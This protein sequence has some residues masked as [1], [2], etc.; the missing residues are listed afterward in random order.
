MLN[1][2]TVIVTEK[3]ADQVDELRQAVAQAVL[4]ALSHLAAKTNV[5]HSATAGA[6]HEHEQKEARRNGSK[7]KARRYPKLSCKVELSYVESFNFKVY[8]KTAGVLANAERESPFRSATI[9]AI[10]SCR[11]LSYMWFHF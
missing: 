3:R 1:S 2:S 10:F 7:F 8:I 4:Y 9:V 11:R 6:E 5:A